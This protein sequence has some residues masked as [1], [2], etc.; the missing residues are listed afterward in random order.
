MMF[1]K[2]KSIEFASSVKR[3][4]D[5]HLQTCGEISDQCIE[6]ESATKPLFELKGATKRQK[7]HS[8]SW[9]V[10]AVC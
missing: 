10:S 3:E 1:L 6:S 9:N 2:Q 8:A 7:E 4:R 5:L